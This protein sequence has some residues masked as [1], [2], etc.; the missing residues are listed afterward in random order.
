MMGDDRTHYAGLTGVG[1][2][3]IPFHGTAQD[4][5]DLINSV[6]T[7][8][9]ACSCMVHQDPWGNTCQGHPCPGHSFLCEQD[10]AGRTLEWTIPDVR[11]ETH[12]TS[13]ALRS[14]VNRLDRLMFARK[15]M[16]RWVNGEH[17]L[18][19]PRCNVAKCPEDL[20]EHVATCRNAA[21]RFLEKINRAPEDFDF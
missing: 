8:M 2:P 6:R 15:L 10:S 20:D 21:V 1:L 7:H 11:G 17:G 5:R 3:V 4:Q 14:T 19:C 16:M 18:R 9:G 13:G 12:F